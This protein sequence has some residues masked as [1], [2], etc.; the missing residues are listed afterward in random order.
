MRWP[1]VTDVTTAACVTLAESV[2]VNASSEPFAER[3]F[4]VTWKRSMPLMVLGVQVPASAT[5]NSLGSSAVS[6]TRW[7]MTPDGKAQ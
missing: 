3:F 2:S 5:S 1:R 7:G 4:P 6:S